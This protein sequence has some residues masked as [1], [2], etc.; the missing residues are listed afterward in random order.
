MKLRIV[1]KIRFSLHESGWT[2]A[3]CPGLVSRP[4]AKAQEPVARSRGLVIQAPKTLSWCQS[5]GTSGKKQRAVARNRGLVIQPPKLSVDAYFELL[6]LGC[7]FLILLSNRSDSPR[8]RSPWKKKRQKYGTR[9]NRLYS[10]AIHCLPVWRCIMFIDSY[11]R[12]CRI[13]R[14]V[15]K[16]RF[17]LHESGSTKARCPGLVSGPSPKAQELVARSRWLVIQPPKLSVGAKAQEP[18]ARS[19]G[20]CQ[21]VEDLLFNPKHSQLVHILSFHSQGVVFLFSIQQI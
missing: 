14:F 8:F 12:A 19:R 20:Q 4:S 21:E 10:R 16:I 7:G 6:F 11:L 1:Q 5:I 17:S 2:K 15:K 13:L 9:Q 18:V 3:W